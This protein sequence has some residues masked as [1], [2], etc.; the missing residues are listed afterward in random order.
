MTRKVHTVA[1]AAAS[2]EAEQFPRAR[3]LEI[4]DVPLADGKELGDA[5]VPVVDERAV[6]TQARDMEGG[7]YSVMPDGGEQ[8]PTDF[9]AGIDL[10]AVGR[11]VTVANSQP[12]EVITPEGKAAI[13]EDQRALLEQGSDA[14][15]ILLKTIDRGPNATSKELERAVHSRMRPYLI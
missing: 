7:P 15:K 3:W 14:A 11:A 10:A 8:V 5:D 1:D 9:Y 13:P 6:F 12:A 4:A 2:G